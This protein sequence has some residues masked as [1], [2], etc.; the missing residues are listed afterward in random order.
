MSL[1]QII[2]KGVSLI[3]LHFRKY[4]LGITVQILQVGEEGR[5]IDQVKDVRLAD[6]IQRDTPL[7]F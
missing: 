3:F 1:Q 5:F 6:Y 2:N 4:K 7:F